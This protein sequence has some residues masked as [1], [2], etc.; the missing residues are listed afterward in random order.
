MKHHPGFTLI[1]ISIV[2]VLI[3]LIAAGVMGTRALIRTSQIQSAMSEY[4]MYYT[5]IRNF[6]S[7]YQ[8]LPG[9]FS[10]AS[11]QWGEVS[12]SCAVGAGSG[13]ATCNGNGDGLVTFSSTPRYEHLLAWRHLGL[14]GFIPQNFTGNTTTGGVCN[15]DLKAGENAPASKIK[16]G[17]WKFE[18]GIYGTAYDG[19]SGGTMAFPMS[20]ALDPLNLQALWLGSSLQDDDTLA[21]SCSH[22]QIPLLTGNEAFEIDQKF[23]D[24]SATTGQI[25]AQYNNGAVYL[26]CADASGIGGYRHD[27]AGVNCS[28]AF[29]IQP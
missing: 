2:L 18:T 10:A 23:D 15:Y 11:A 4:Q 21:T 1:E 22:S 9:D 14:S 6:R 3:A 17:M 5:A 12:A 25:R 20:L 13:T 24:G 26:P 7:K 27:T 16:G 28:L 19:S 29:I 8:A